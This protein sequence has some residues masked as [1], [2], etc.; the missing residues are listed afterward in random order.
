MAHPHWANAPTTLCTTFD[1]LAQATWR[2]LQRTD[3]ARRRNRRIG[4]REETVTENNLIVVEE[5]HRVHVA[6]EQFDVNTESHITGADWDWWFVDQLQGTIL[7]LRIQAKKI[8]P[9]LRFFRDVDL[10][11]LQLLESSAAKVNAYPLYCFYT[12]WRDPAP[13]WSVANLGCNDPRLGCL[14]ARSSY[15]QFVR[16]RR[17]RSVAAIAVGARPW[18]ALVCPVPPPVPWT[19]A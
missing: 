4:T 9:T 10:N 8:D 5:L 3:A 7:G 2:R 17:R 12:Y 11:Q 18:Q 15:V 13:K 6:V 14:I 19:V 1:W 16:A